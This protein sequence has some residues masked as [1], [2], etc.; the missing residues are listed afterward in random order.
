M[1]RRMVAGD[2]VVEWLT[3]CELYNGHKV[4]ESK[5]YNSLRLFCYIFEL[6]SSHG[7]DGI[8]VQCTMYPAWSSPCDHC[9]KPK[10]S[11]FVGDAGRLE[12]RGA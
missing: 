3:I 2:M 6:R 9:M 11:P 10:P 4:G 8:S 7:T 1:P 5:Y 12:I